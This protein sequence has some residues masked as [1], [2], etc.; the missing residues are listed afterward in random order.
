MKLGF[1]CEPTANAYYRAMLP[2]RALERRGR[3][4]HWPINTYDPPVHNLLDCELVHC[5]R[6]TDRLAA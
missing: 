4:V 6:R 2:M 1:I 3:T 5:Y